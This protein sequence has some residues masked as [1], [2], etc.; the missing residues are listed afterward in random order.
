MADAPH[1]SMNVDAGSEFHGRADA[2]DAAILAEVLAADQLPIDRTVSR[3]AVASV[4]VLTDAGEV[5]L[6]RNRTGGWGTI[7]GHVE[8]SDRSLREAAMRELAE[9][10]GIAIRSDSLEPLLFLADHEEFRPGCAHADFC[11]VLRVPERIA[12]TAADDVSELGWFALDDLPALNE[13]MTKAV[14]A[15]RR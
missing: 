9:E 7:G 13:H 1:P 8:P 14:T 15:L 4:L 3:H 6:A 11:F 5:L 2:S 12:A 10:A